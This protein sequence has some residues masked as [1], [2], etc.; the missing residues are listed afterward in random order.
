[1]GRWSIDA[2]FMWTNAPHT[3]YDHDFAKYPLDGGHRRTAAGCCTGASTSTTTAG[4][5]A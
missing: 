4:G 1:M 2:N 3:G 5:C